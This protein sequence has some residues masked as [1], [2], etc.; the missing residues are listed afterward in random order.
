MMSRDTFCELRVK[1]TVVPS[2]RGIA[3][4]F[5]SDRNF[6]AD[7]GDCT[8]VLRMAS[9]PRRQVTMMR[10]KIAANVSGSQPPWA[11]FKRLAVKKLVS[12]TIKTM[13][14]EAATAIGHFHR[15]RIARYKRNVVSNMV[16]DTA[17]P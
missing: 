2:T 11:I 13:A 17:V 8:K 6:S 14:T 5:K 3:P 9:T 4:H 15:S 10:N 12:T 16:V 1:N 7:C